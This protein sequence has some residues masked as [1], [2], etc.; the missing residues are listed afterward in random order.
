MLSDSAN[1]ILSKRGDAAWTQTD[2]KRGKDRTWFP[3]RH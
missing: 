3:S 1:G 2:G